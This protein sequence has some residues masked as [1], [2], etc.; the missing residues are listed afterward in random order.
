MATVDRAT[1]RLTATLEVHGDDVDRTRGEALMRPRFSI[2]GLMGVVF[3]LAVGFAGLGIASPLW[4]DDAMFTVTVGA[5]GG[6][7]RRGGR[8]AQGR[9]AGRRWASPSSGGPI[10]WRPSVCGPMSTASLLRHS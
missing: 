8:R 1:D 7:G 4:A 9:L 10:C 2:A 6:V 5:S 3:L